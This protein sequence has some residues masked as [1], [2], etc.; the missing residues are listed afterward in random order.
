MPHKRTPIAS[1]NLCGLARL[2]RGYTQACLENVALWHERDISHSS[3]ERVALPDSTIL[4]DFMFNR[5]NGVLSGLQVYPENMKRNMAKTVEI[6]GSQKVLLA[7]VKKGWRRED[8][9][10]LVQDHAMKAWLEGYSFRQ[11]VEEDAKIMKDLKRSE[12]D[13]CFDPE[14]YVRHTQDILRRAGL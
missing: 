9:Y 14:Y 3:V 1:E 7:L 12:L 4:L 10:K 2:I 6:I 5:L 11:L 13:P 8:A